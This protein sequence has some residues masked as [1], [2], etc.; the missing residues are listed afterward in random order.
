M[1]V[2]PVVVWLTWKI[3]NPEVV[4]S[5]PTKFNDYNFSFQNEL[6]LTEQ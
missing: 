3:S 6:I 5:N 2:Q 1:S 4:G